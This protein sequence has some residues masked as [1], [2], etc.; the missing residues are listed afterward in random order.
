MI[1]ERVTGI[2][3]KDH[4]KREYHLK[5]VRGKQGKKEEKMSTYAAVPALKYFEVIRQ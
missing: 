5:E 4:T 3:E 1:G 2:M